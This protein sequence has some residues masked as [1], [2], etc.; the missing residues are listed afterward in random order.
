MEETWTCPVCK[1]AFSITVQGSDKVLLS[2]RDTA[3][4]MKVCRSPKAPRGSPLR[5][6]EEVRKALAAL[7]GPEDTDL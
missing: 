2:A 6:C 7:S 1:S 4:W 3:A 5:R